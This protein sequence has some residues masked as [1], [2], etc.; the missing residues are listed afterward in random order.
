MPRPDLNQPVIF[1][2][3]G[4]VFFSDRPA[5]VTTVLG[6]CISVV[7]HHRELRIGAICHALL[8]QGECLGE[9][10]L[11]Y[12]DCSILWMIG[13]FRRREVPLHELDVKLFGGSD[14]WD[15]LSARQM[16]VGCQNIDAALELIQAMGLRLAASCVG[17]PRGRKLYFYTDTG[18]VLVQY[19]NRLK[20]TGTT[21]GGACRRSDHSEILT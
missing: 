15:F 19:Q 17:G 2:K 4:N 14:M 7:L 5:V 20:P 21:A 12:V 9:E 1:L 13:V 18:E 8:P 6:S 11:R 16:S 10:R 3:P